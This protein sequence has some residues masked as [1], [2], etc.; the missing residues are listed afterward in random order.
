MVCYKLS[1]KYMGFMKKVERVFEWI[2]W[3][4][5]LIIIVA[6]IASIVSA[7]ILVV[8][9]TMD[10][11]YII[12]SVFKAFQGVEQY[13]K[14]QYKVLSTIVSAM[15]LYLIATVLLIFGI[16]LYEL[17][18]SK[19]DHVERDDNSGGI[20]KIHSLDELKEKLLKVIHVVL[21]V[22]FFKFA[23]KLEYK[24]ILDLLYL[25]IGILLIATSVYMTK[26]K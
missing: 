22:Y 5:R 15:D 24:T 26:K 19:I 2:L 20:L 21:V 23:I 18:I 9:G 17:F 4:S 6:V 12:T 10:I 7:V 13:G 1:L 14:I 8:F 11:I 16:G 3:E 25:A